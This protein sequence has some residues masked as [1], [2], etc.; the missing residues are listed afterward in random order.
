MPHKYA[1]EPK[2]CIYFTLGKCR[3][4]EKFCPTGAI[5][6]NQ[7]DQMVTVDVGAVIL[8]PGFKPFDP[9]KY[10][11]LGYKYI[12]DVVTSLEYERLLSVSGPNKGTLLRPSDHTQPKKIA[13]L[14]CVGSR[15]Q[16]ECGNS[17]C[18]SICCMVAVKQSLIS[19]E[20]ITGRKLERTVF[21]MD[22][23]SH[24]K[25]SERYFESAKKQGVAFV[26][27]LPHTMD[28]GKDGTGVRMRY[29]DEKGQVLVASFDMAVLSIGLEAPED[30]I[31]LADQF[32]IQL[33]HHHFA[34]TSC[35]EPVDSSK[36]GVYVIGAFQAPK[37][38]PR[39]VVQASAAA[40]GASRL[41]IKKR[42]TS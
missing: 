11:H 14:L 32:G 12:S 20:H 39:S 34:T 25:E 7:K 41:L 5:D 28:P 23:R 6:F 2:A 16:N 9:L 40:A 36:K 21:F 15:N 27:A 13:W 22:L 8:A 1:I 42:D 10:D 3:A 35:F 17:Y 38:I 18:S 29:V 31:G 30:A 24:G 37:A 19:I 33:D 4:C 26:R